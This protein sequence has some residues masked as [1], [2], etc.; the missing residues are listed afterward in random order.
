[1]ETDFRQIYASEARRY[2]A[3]VAAE[4]WQRKLLPAV[5]DIVA[6]DG[7]A[8]IEFGAGT[9]RLTRQLLPYARSLRAF[10]FSPHMLQ[11]A[12]R[13]LSR[14]SLSTWSLTVADNRAMPLPAHCADVAIAGWSFGHSTIWSEANWRAEVDR[15][16]GEMLRV[17]RPGA[18]ALVIETLGSGSETPQPPTPTLADFYRW[19]EEERGFT[20]HWLRTDFRFASVEEGELL[21]RFFFGEDL[22]R[23]IRRAGSR[24]FPECTGIWWRRR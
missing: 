24:I 23:Q 6:L 15:A 16:L 14:M 21:L 2:D 8:I 17:L 5:A 1:M 18:T 19:L 12:Q 20:R 9:G 7:A 11:I 13:H 10:D 4:D 22:A 3:F